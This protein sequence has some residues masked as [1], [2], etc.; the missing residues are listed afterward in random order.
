MTSTQLQTTAFYPATLTYRSVYD[1]RVRELRC[2]DGSLAS[3][4]SVGE[5]MRDK[6]EQEEGG[7]WYL[8]LITCGNGD[9]HS[10]PHPEET[11]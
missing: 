1:G 3:L 8:S 7:E 10:F 11:V 5:I 4:H 2:T 6:V 9:F